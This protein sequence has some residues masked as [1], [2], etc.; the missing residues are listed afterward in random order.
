MKITELIQH[1]NNGGIDEELR[2]LYGSDEKVLAVQRDRYLRAIEGFRK[3]FPDREDIRLY[4]APG[5]SEIIRQ[6]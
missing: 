5:R 4:S 3:S 6:N 2:V 1:I